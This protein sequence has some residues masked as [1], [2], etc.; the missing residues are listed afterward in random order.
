MKAVIYAR[1]SAGPNQTDQSI[2][3]QLRICKQY[4]KNKGLEYI[5]HYADRHISGKTDNRPEFQRMITDAEAKKFSVLV[6]YST[7]RFSRS[8]YDSAIYKKKLKDLGIKICYAAENIP[9][10]PEGIL[11]EALMEGWAQYY[12]EELSR[13]IKRGMHESAMK[14][15]YLGSYPPIG[16]KINDDKDYIVDED[17]APHIVEVF[18]RFLQGATYAD[19]GR[20]LSSKGFR[21]NAGKVFSGQTIKRT[22]MSERYI[23]TYINSGVRIEN[24]I[25]AIVD[26]DL[27][28]EVQKKM[29]SEKKNHSKKGNFAL[30]G[31]L[32]CGACKNPMTGASGT[33]KTGAV[34]Y[35]YVCRSK[36]RK[37]INRDKLE[38]FVVE[39]VRKVFSSSSELDLLADKLFALQTERNASE[40]DSGAQKNKLKDVNKQIDNLVIAIASRPDSQALLSKLDELEDLKADLEIDIATNKKRPMLSYEEIRSGL[41]LFLKGFNFDDEMTTRKRIID[42]FVHKVIIYDSG[43]TIQFNVGD[44]DEL[45]TTDLIE[46]DQNNVISTKTKQHAITITDDNMLFYF[47]SS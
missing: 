3:G 41:E 44:G 9:E 19:L 17:M 28:Y 21:T 18:K 39:Q 45:K 12:S 46:F 26:K 38:S 31:K 20:Y 10:G 4:I 37:N 5:G 6:V 13:K 47:I 29:K 35:Y 25:P 22:L 1:Y 15:K 34:H 40:N 43:I 27:F 16:Y 7:D 30:S 11:M 42:A 14:A 23:G 2:D 33:S 8:K 32:Y 36:C 24:A